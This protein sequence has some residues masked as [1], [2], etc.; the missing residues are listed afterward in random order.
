MLSCLFCLQNNICFYISS[1]L[2]RTIYCI[3]QFIQF[4]FDVGFIYPRVRST[5]TYHTKEQQKSLIIIDLPSNVCTH[6]QRCCVYNTDW[7]RESHV[8]LVGR[9]TTRHSQR[10]LP[11]IQRLDISPPT[12]GRNSWKQDCSIS[13]SGYENSWKLIQKRSTS[14]HW[15]QKLAQVHIL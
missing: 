11:S 4:H 6:S 7:A 8:C 12:R 14:S 5:S 10:C 13:D 9:Q 1:I 3:L 15:K 2:N